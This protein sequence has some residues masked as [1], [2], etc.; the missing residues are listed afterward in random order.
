MEDQGKKWEKVIS[1]TEDISYYFINDER[2]VSKPY[3]IRIIDTPGFGS[4]GDAFD[5]KMM[6][7][8]EHFF[9]NKIEELDYILLVVKSS[10]TRWTYSA[11]SVCDSVQQMFGNVARERFILICTFAD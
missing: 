10:M 5:G 9:K 3:H 2:A 8:F 7:K 1:M 4:R 11:K 6:E